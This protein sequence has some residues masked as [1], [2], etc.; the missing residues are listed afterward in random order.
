MHVLA[1]GGLCQCVAVV[2]REAL[3]LRREADKAE[4]A[5]DQPPR[6]GK[7]K[8][9]AD[10]MQ[11]WGQLQLYVGRRIT[12][13]DFALQLRLLQHKWWHAYAKYWLTALLVQS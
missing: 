3:R 6:L 10:A 13:Q 1:V 2:C 8:F 7:L 4:K 12:A 11:V 5:L 9:T